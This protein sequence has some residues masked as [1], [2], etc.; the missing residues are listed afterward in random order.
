MIYKIYINQLKIL[1]IIGIL[2]K[3]RLNSQS[4]IVDCEIQY[5]RDD[6]DFVNYAEISDLIKN[7]LISKKYFLLE[8]ALDEITKEIKG[9]FTTIK[10]IKL[11]LSKPEILPNCIVAVENFK[12]Y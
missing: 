7:L 4:I 3:E 10:S 5:K 8:D 2:E 9:K 6:S 1:A 11:K 12:K